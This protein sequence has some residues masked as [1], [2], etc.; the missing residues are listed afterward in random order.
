LLRGIVRR[1]VA[2]HR[3]RKARLRRGDSQAEQ[4]GLEPSLEERT[5]ALAPHTLLHAALAVLESTHPQPFTVVACYLAGL[6]IP[7][8]A[9]ALHIPVGTAYTRFRFAVAALRATL[10]GWTAGEASAA[11]RAALAARR[12]P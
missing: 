9:A 5:L 2:N 1:R 4:T 6:S 10:V 8:T 11:A 12:R 3:R 7:R